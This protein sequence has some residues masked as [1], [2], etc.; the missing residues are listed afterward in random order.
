MSRNGSRGGPPRCGHDQSGLPGVG[1]RAGGVRGGAGGRG[2]ER[3][4]RRRLAWQTRAAP[5]VLDGL[6]TATEEIGPQSLLLAGEFPVGFGIGRA[7]LS[8][9]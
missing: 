3:S 8:L 2:K 6:V 9:I 5:L 4:R 1:G 7:R